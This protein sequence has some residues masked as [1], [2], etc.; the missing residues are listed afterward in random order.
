MQIVSLCVGCWRHS[1]PKQGDYDTIQ[2]LHRITR[3]LQRGLWMTSNRP[4]IQSSS[5]VQTQPPGSGPDLDNFRQSSVVRGVIPSNSAC[6]IVIILPTPAASMY[7]VDIEVL[8]GADS[9]LLYQAR[10]L[11]DT[12]DR[13]WYKYWQTTA[14]AISW[15]QQTIINAVWRRW[16]ELLG[17]EMQQDTDTSYNTAGKYD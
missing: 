6:D 10:L 1:P 5:L 17:C 11:S 4:M 14:E 16:D 2:S 12:D 8:D 7:A 9:A 15:Q 3:G 13:L